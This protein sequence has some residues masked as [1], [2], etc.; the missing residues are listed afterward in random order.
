MYVILQERYTHG[1]FYLHIVLS[2]TFSNLDMFW[3]CKI[4]QWQ[5]AGNT[6]PQNCSHLAN[7]SV[8]WL[9]LVCQFGIAWGGKKMDT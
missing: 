4:V 9:L 8:N 5:Q 6:T 2:P 7:Q 1:E 3:I